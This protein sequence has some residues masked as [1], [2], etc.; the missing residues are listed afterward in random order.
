[1][2]WKGRGLTSEVLEKSILY[3]TEGVK[4]VKDPLVLLRRAVER[5]MELAQAVEGHGSK[6]GEA[7]LRDLA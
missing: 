2:A 6:P 4:Q 1:V 7:S 3:V 5:A